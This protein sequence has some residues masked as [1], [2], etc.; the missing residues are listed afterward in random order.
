MGY[1]RQERTVSSVWAAGLR[2]SGSSFSATSELELT[3]W[4]TTNR[5]PQETAA[6]ATASTAAAERMRGVEAA[7]R[8]AWGALGAAVALCQRNS[9][10]L[11]PA[12]CEQL[13]FDVLERCLRPLHTATAAAS[14]SLPPS[15]SAPG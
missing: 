9:S 1:V 4:A 3:A 15:P 10:R 7:A 8:D 2:A 14:R 6:Q 5:S 11:P 13:W 12:E